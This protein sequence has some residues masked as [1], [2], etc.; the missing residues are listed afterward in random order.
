MCRMNIFTSLYH[1]SDW[2]RML[3]CAFMLF[4]YSRSS[5]LKSGW[6]F[7][8]N[9]SRTDARYF[10]VT[11]YVQLHLRDVSIISFIWY[12]IIPEECTAYN[13][14]VLSIIYHLFFFL[15]CQNFGFRPAF[16]SS[17]LS[18]H[19]VALQALPRPVFLSSA[20]LFPPISD[21]LFSSIMTQG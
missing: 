7:C 14:T 1:H 4:L 3:G 10:N 19:R 18:Y 17:P 21:S 15:R 2:L 16:F 6:C 5:K 12:Q 20:S 8:L 9:E 13:Y 11:A